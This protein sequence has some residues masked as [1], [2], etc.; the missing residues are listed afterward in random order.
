VTRVASAY[1]RR[2]E[3]ATDLLDLLC[4]AHEAIEE[5]L[6]RLGRALATR[7]AA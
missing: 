3:P 2:V 1:R 4:V 6:G 5:G 7:T